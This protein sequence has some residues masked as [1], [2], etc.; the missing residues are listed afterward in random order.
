M[1][2]IRIGNNVHVTW[3]VFNGNGSPFQL[4]GKVKKLYV[5]SASLEKEITTYEIQY[6][7]EV[8]FTLY[9]DDL[10][11]FGT[12]KLV[13]TLQEN[14]STAEDATYDLTQVFQIVS[15]S[16]P[17]W[18]KPL[19]G[20]V[21]VTFE[22]VLNNLIV[23]TVEGL[24]A[25]D[26]AVAQGFTGN[27]TE[28]LESLKGRDGTSPYIG[29]NNNWFIYDDE[30]GEFVDSGVN[31]H[32]SIDPSDVVKDWNINDPTDPRYVANRTHYAIEAGYAQIKNVK[33]AFAGGGRGT[34]PQ[35][36]YLDFWVD[37]RPD[38]MFERAQTTNDSITYRL[39]G[40]RMIAQTA[41]GVEL[42]VTFYQEVY[43][44]VEL[45]DYFSDSSKH[46]ITA[47]VTTTLFNYDGDYAVSS[48]I[49]PL[50]RVT[51]TSLSERSEEVVKLDPKFLPAMKTINN[52]SIVGEGNINVAADI[53]LDNTP[54]SGSQNAVK[55]GGVYSALQDKQATISDL[56]TIRSGA[57]A[58]AT[59]YQKPSSGIPKTDLASAVQTSLSK[60]DSA[61][62]EHQSL[63]GKQDKLVSGT[64]IKTINNQPILG[65]GNINIE[66]SGGGEDNIIEAVS[67]NGTPA[68]IS[69][70]TAEITAPIP[71]ALSEL[72]PDTTHRTVTDAEKSAWN[73]KQNALTFDNA[74]SSG[75]NNPVK[76][77]GVYAAL[78]DKYEKPSGGIPDT[79]LTSAVQALLGKTIASVTSA[80][81]GA[82]VIT[83]S[84]GDTYTIDLNHNHPQYLK[85]VFLTDEADM[86]ATPEANTLYLIEEESNA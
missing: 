32:G 49:T 44:Q 8:A 81:D 56:S 78:E 86:P 1:K 58:G 72:S 29:D 45:R 42:I 39:P 36:T 5:S 69:G 13:L 16:Y 73:A 35:L 60:A 53:T 50:A 24:S 28:W 63:D 30:A 79:D 9:A 75:S 33:F 19:T 17:G 59:A 77:G 55:S 15:H 82:V 65:S 66:V 40:W 71:S 2:T 46:G 38:L 25:Y 54:T 57:S 26:I 12:Y 61:L 7:N 11:R 14:E 22:S 64:N 6:R 34:T 62:Q 4:I 10:R 27:V 52:E 48:P 23:D 20:E 21:D 70:K 74:P 41:L 37:G 84:N 80:Q 83:L 43:A 85:Y 51:L 68:T 31:A 76:S 47:I 67:F 3:K 18:H